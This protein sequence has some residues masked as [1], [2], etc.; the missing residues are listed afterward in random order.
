M[1]TTSELIYMD[2]AATTS[3]RPEV[4]EVM[5]NHFSQ[6]YGNPSSI[7]A[8]GQ[9][10]RK[11]MDNSRETVANVLGASRNEIVFTSG[12]TESDNLA[13]K[14]AAL[15]LREKGNHIITSS[16][17]HHAVIH[18]CEQLMEEG[19]EVTFLPVD[20]YGKVDP[21]EVVS[22]IRDSTIL[23]SVMYANN[24]IGTVE[25]IPEIS[26][27]VNQEA[28]T[29]GQK[30]IIHT[31]AV[32]A[33]GYL[34]L[35]VDQLGVDLLSISAHKF[36]GPKGVGAL[37][38]RRRTPFTPQ[39]MG[40]GQER[41]RRSGTENIPGIV[42]LSEALRLAEEEREMS[43]IHCLELRELIISG[44]EEMID[45]VN[46][47]GHPSERL[48]NN[49]NI[50][51]EGVE[52]EPILQGLDFAGIAASS[53]SACSTASLELSHVL[54]S[55]GLTSELNRGSLRITIGLDNTKQEVDYLL[56]V[57]PD[58]ISKLRHMPSL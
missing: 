18:T 42:G 43:N 39:Q 44:I 26:K 55:I 10:A 48:S 50:S 29:R 4:V 28:E 34:D 16:I 47:N 11:S 46:L 2:H 35:N 25:P 1:I 32:Q 20:R 9:E 8:L 19:F 7:Y 24:E 38:V 33:A 58:I 21:N 17:E 53:R 6:G 41:D 15:A 22:S 37:Y 12:G 51:F 13:I 40:G 52:A 36:R 57:L 14:G 49:I 45:R 31:D 54:K 30:I 23:V 5:M 27:A 56:S 3:V